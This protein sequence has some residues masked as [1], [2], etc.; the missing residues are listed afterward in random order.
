MSLSAEFT[1]EPFTPGDPGP[2]V[3][4]AFVAA[5]AV[6]AI[7][8]VGPFGTLLRATSDDLVFKAVDAA[9][10]AAVAAGATRVSFQL[11]VD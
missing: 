5:E 3:K 8:E 2:H 10:R 1:V 9:V 7:L 11:F 4:A 6:G